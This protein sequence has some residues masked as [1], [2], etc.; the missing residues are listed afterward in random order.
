MDI[1]ERVLEMIVPSA[2]TV[3]SLEDKAIRL[4]AVVKEYAADHGI[5]VEVR[6]AG[7]F[8]T[9]MT[10]GASPPSYISSSSS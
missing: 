1:E 6:M 7:S 3:A 10:M 9:A 8:S 2:E 5:D 4:E